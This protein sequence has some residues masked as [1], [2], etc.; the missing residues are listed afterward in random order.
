MDVGKIY[1]LL[2]HIRIHNA[3]AHSSLYT[4]GVPAMTAWLGA[5]HA[6]QRRIRRHTGLEQVSFV[7]TGI[8]CH[9]SDLQVCGHCIAATANPLHKCL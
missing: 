2:S 3:N 1:I 4:I 9:R 7:K 6:L 8:S 5:V